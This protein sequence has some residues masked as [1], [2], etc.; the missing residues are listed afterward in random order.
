MADTSTTIPPVNILMPTVPLPSKK[1]KESST[2]LS[3]VP[4]EGDHTIE[5]PVPWRLARKK[6]NGAIILIHEDNFPINYSSNVL[7]H[8]L[9]IAML[10][11]SF[12]TLE[13]MCL[14]LEDIIAYYLN[15]KCTFIIPKHGCSKESIYYNEPYNFIAIGPVSTQEY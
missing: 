12:L 10:T 6:P 1:N 15:V 9:L 8:K 7:H 3:F 2:L 5:G 13:A 11:I 4:I 14:H